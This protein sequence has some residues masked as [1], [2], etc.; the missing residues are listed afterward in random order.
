M[1]GR[2]IRRKRRDM[3]IVLLRVIGQR[4]S[5][6]LATRPRQIKRMFQEMLLRNVIV[7]LVEMMIHGWILSHRL[8]QIFTDERNR[9]V[10]CVSS[11]VIAYADFR[12]CLM[13]RMGMMTQS[14]RLLS[15]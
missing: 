11:V 6:Q 10:I 15:S 7:D 3:M 2:E 12:M 14:G 5:A 9:I 4:L 13:P 1:H 8:A